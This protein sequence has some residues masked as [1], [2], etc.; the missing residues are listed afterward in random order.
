MRL[1][2]QGSVEQGNT[3]ECVAMFVLYLGCLAA[4]WLFTQALDTQQ[5]TV[6]TWAT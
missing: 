4:T 6:F 1:D 3:T 5:K 2:C